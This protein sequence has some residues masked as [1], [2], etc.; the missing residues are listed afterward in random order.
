MICLLRG[1][2]R[3]V[4]RLHVMAV[5]GRKQ[6]FFCVMWLFSLNH[7]YSSSFSPSHCTWIFFLMLPL[8][9]LRL[10]LP[11]DFRSE[12]SKPADVSHSLIHVLPLISVFYCRAFIM[13]GVVDLWSKPLLSFRFAL[14]WLLERVR[15]RLR[16]TLL[17][18]PP[19]SLSSAWGIRPAVVRGVYFQMYS[20]ML[21]V[22]SWTEALTLSA[23]ICL[24]IL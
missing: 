17:L 21:L 2:V 4:R 11:S 23:F 5:W 20:W 22:S 15:E 9:L 16:E 8:L 12:V 19:H 24:L 10:Y 18:L 7:C 13:S 14:K 6:C 3:D 1:W